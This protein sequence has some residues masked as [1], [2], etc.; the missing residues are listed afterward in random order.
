MVSEL[1]QG[2][3]RMDCTCGWEKEVENKDPRIDYEGIADSV[4]GAHQFTH[5]F[6]EDGH[7]VRRRWK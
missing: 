3:Y 6:K 4:A 1:P 2:T 7:E 5:D